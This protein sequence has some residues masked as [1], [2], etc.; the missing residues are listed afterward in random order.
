MTRLLFVAIPLLAA[1]LTFAAGTTAQA[2]MPGPASADSVPPWAWS[3][4]VGGLLSIVSILGAALLWAART[5]IVGQLRRLD[6]IEQRL[7]DG[8]KIQ[9]ETRDEVR[10]LH[11]L[12]DGIGTLHRR[13]DGIERVCLVQHGDGK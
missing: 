6:A 3:I 1:L 8:E 9:Q 10:S 5:W 11:K 13:M 7:A 4:A 2:Q 12:A